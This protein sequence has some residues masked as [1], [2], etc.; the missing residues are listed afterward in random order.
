MTASSA[1]QPAL[2]FRRRGPTISVR[3]YGQNDFER[4]DEETARGSHLCVGSMSIGKVDI[5]VK[6]RWKEARWGVLGDDKSPGGVVYMDLTFKQPHGYWL[7]SARVFVTLSEDSSTYALGKARRRDRV[8]SRI[9]NSINS[10]YDLQLTEHFGPQFLTGTK[11]VQTE[12]KLNSF[13]PTIGAMGVAEIGGMG[14]SSATL[15]QRES[16]WIFKGTIRKPR[17]SDS[18]R[19]LEWELSENQ[20]DPNQPHKQDYQT[21]FAFEHNYRP[22]FMRVEVEGKLRSKTQSAK[23]KVHHNFLRFSSNPN[24]KD[25]ST[26]THIDLSENKG[27]QKSLDPVATSLNMAMEMKNGLNPPLEMPDPTQAHY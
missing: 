5:D 26:L 4:F 25:C 1:A 9:R 14:H 19:T 12:S 10:D 22:V 3:K 20:L 7:E 16:R 11:T 8:S 23:H 27:F 13:I 6:Y 17:D 15:K 21:A 24:K 2:R 18:F